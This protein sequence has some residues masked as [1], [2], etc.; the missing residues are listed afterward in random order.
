MA[1][2]SRADGAS[3]RLAYCLQQM[4]LAGVSNACAA[5]F[6]NP[7]DV[8]K[9]RLQMDGE[10]ATGKRYR[11]VFHCGQT[12]FR[13]EGVKGLYRGIGASVCRELSYSGI[14][15]GMYEPTKEMLGATDPTKTPLWLK[16]A[17][18]ALTG[19]TGSILANPFDLVKVRMQSATGSGGR[20]E[21]SSVFSA[22]STIG[23]EGG[24]IRGLWRGS[25]PTV[26]RA[27]LLT[28]RCG[29]AHRSEAPPPLSSPTKLFA[30]SAVR[31]LSCRR[32]T[33]GNDDSVACFL[34]IHL[35]CPTGFDQ[36][37]A[38]PRT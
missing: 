12:L 21:Y 34:C 8:V 38:I 6:T 37:S 35:L 33:A 9:V 7:V 28:A 4:A 20:A 17:S 14:R 27:A 19:A 30:P 16:I 13:D 29:A 23:R 24:G 26:Q 15:M 18:G 5:C 32:K 36:L 2:P 3:S 25:S 22:L 1:P 10:G 11:G 31:I